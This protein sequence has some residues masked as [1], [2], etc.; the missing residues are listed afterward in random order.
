[1]LYYAQF[2]VVGSRIKARFTPLGG[3]NVATAYLC[4]GLFDGP[5]I[6]GGFSD[7]PHLLESGKTQSPAIAGLVY[8][9][10]YKE[11]SATVY[12]SF[13]SKRWF[14]Q[15]AD[16]SLKGTSAAD[17]TQQAFFS[18]IAGAVNGQ[19][20]GA[21]NVLVTIDYLVVF[22]DPRELVQS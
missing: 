14:K 9:G 1:M 3:N 11:P 17:P 19:N 22:S 12:K 15:A 4:V 13:S 8:Q 18:V 6:P 7:V 20:S 5:A 16:D 2:H 21:I 10:T